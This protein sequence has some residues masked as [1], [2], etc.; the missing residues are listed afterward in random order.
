[1]RFKYSICSEAKINRIWAH[2]GSGNVQKNSV[3]RHSQ[4]NEHMK[5]ELSC[6]KQTSQTPVCVADGTESYDPKVKEKDIKLFLYNLFVW[7]KKL[8]SSDMTNTLL[9]LQSLNG[10]DLECQNP[11]WNTITV[12]QSCTSDTIQRSII[13]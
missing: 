6:M 4:S 3:T 12:I 8:Q 7:P 13:K 9:K 11:S 10:V 1:M 2:E 5:A